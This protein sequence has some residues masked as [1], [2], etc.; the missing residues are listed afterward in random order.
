MIAAGGMPALAQ[1]KAPSTWIWP[2]AVVAV[3]AVLTAVMRVSFDSFAVFLLPLADDFGWGRAETA[4]IYGCMMLFFGIGC[5]IAGRMMDRFGPRLTYVTGTVVIAAA[6]QLTASADSLWQFYLG[7]GVVVGLGGAL[8]GVVSH[9]TL[10]ARWF[11][12]NLTIAIATAAAASGVGMLVFA[13]L[14]QLLIQTTGWRA[15][16]TELSHASAILAAV[17]LVLPWRR[18]SR[19]QAAD[20]AAPA[21]VGKAAGPNPQRPSASAFRHV[22][23]WTLFGIQ[24]LT[25]FGM[26]ALNPQ[27]VAFLVEQG[28]EP[29]AAASAFGATGLAGTV[30]L[31]VFA[32]LADRRGRG[33]A[34]TVSYSMTLIGFGLLLAIIALPVWWLV[35]LFVVIYGPTFGSR[36]PI[37]NALVPRLFGRGPGLGLIMGSVHLGMGAGGA[38]GATLGGYLH[39]ASGY[40][41]VIAVASAANAA[42]LVLYW[43]VGAI[44]RA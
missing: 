40:G 42:A 12:A 13:P 17:L 25:A 38:L 24:F 39:D 43:S 41:T 6:F 18:L 33:L 20:G 14:I 37:V 9:A 28:F 16:Y 11:R 1:D 44:R 36:G 22:G 34:M 35:G 8:I 10:L 3:C 2:V 31:I 29:L 27:I 19:P 26:F 32:W 5:P 15:G 7:I 23:F 4:G 30:G 21:L